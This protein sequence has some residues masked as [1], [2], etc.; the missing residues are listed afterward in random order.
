MAGGQAGW[1]AGEAARARGRRPGAREKLAGKRDG[2]QEK[3]ARARG[4]GIA[5]AA[6]GVDG[7]GVQDLSTRRWPPPS[8]V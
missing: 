6:V 3:P 4:R 1:R 5:A 2:A 7:A 8:R